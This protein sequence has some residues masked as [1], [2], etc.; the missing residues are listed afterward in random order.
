M[1]LGTTASGGSFGSGSVFAL[2]TDGTGHTVLH[3]FLPTSSKPGQWSATDPNTGGLSP[4]AGLIIAGNTLYGTAYYGGSGGA[5]TIFAVNSDG[6]GFR[7]LHNFT[8][9][10]SE[11]PPINNDGAYPGAGL[12]LSGNTLYGTATEGGSAGRGVVF[13]ISTDGTGFTT[14]HNFTGGSDGGRPESGLTLSGSTLYGTT[15]YGGT[16]EQGTVFS[17]SLQPELSILST[18]TSLTLTWPAS[19]TGF[20]LEYSTN[21][22]SQVAWSADLPAAPLLTNGKYEV[23]VTNATGERFYR[24]SK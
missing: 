8:A 22:N 20:N 15:R 17:L 11:W 24:L 12:V 3:S 4:E 6:T 5:G 21:L 16:S 13:S 14:L 1:D 9:P 19:F 2:N 7:V 18:G 10:S 23:S